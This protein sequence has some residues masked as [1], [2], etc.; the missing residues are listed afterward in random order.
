MIELHRVDPA[1]AELVV[2]GVGPKDGREQHA[3]AIPFGVNGSCGRSMGIQDGE[4]R[5]CRHNQ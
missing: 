4:R 3:G 5:D 1:A 2:L